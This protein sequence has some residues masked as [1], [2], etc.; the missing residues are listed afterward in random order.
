MAVLAMTLLSTD[1]ALLGRQFNCHPNVNCHP[2]D[3][4][5]HPNEG[6]RR[7]NIVFILIDDLGWADVGCF[8]S[9]YYETPNIDRL[10]VARD[11]VHRRLCGLRRLFAHAGQHHD[12]QVSGPAAPD[13]LDS[14]RGRLRRRTRCAF[15][16]GG[17]SCRLEEV[18]IAQA[19]KSAGYVS[20]SI[21]KWH[22]GGPPYYPEHHGFDLNVAGSYLGHP[23]LVLLALPRQEA[24]PCRA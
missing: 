23:A 5:C 2:N 10:A 6:G 19:L 4:N 9:R 8:G 7:P 18:T 11:A 16:S 1:R 13:G 21:G 14:R 12:G 3:F 20:A 15:P 22:L 17:S 24:T